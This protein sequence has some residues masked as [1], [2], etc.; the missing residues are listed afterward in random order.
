MEKKVPERKVSLRENDLFYVYD[1]RINK[2]IKADC[3]GT[4]KYGLIYKVNV[5]DEE[6]MNCF[7]CNKCHM[8]YTP[9]P[10]YV[11]ISKPELLTIMNQEEVTA[12][13]K[14]RAED[15]LKQAARLKAEEK[16]KNAA[17]FGDKKP[18]DKKSYGDKKPYDK[19]PYGDRK[20]YD[21]KTSYGE[22]RTYDANRA[23]ENRDARNG[24]KSFSTER[25]YV[26]NDGRK[27]NIVITTGNASGGYYKKPYQKPAYDRGER[28][29]GSAYSRKPYGS[30][31]K[32]PYNREYSE[33]KSYTNNDSSENKTYNRGG[34]TNNGYR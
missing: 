17:K 12:R 20:P 34:Y 13:D 16:R 23:Y 33:R 3:E 10:N 9:Y 8:K 7:E 1:K 15:A 28:T 14:K 5:V 29:E 19:K 25:K 4:V 32:K 18:Y 2:C 27:G 6:N 11:R 26:R 24:E 30:Y 22:R 31:E 21:K